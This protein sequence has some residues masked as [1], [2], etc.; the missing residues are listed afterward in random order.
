M[1][2]IVEASE[3]A[4]IELSSSSST[5]ISLPYI[6][7]KDG[8]PLH[9]NCTLTKAK[10]EQLTDG[11][12]KRLIECGKESVKRSGLSY[13]DLNGILLVGG[14]CRCPNVQKA[15]SD[16]FGVELIKSAN[17]DE[18]VSIGAA[19]QA[20]IIVGGE[21]SSDMV[22]LDVTPLSIG[23]ETMGGVMT[24]LIESNTTI[25]CRK[26][27]I[28]TTAV[29]NQPAVDIR[30]LQGERPMAADN[31]IIGNFQLTDIMPAKRGVPKIEVTFDIDANGILNVS[32][33]DT[34][35]GKEQS[36]RIESKS[37]LSDSEIERIKK[38]AKEHEESDKKLKENAD[39]LNNG[40]A[41]V[42]QTE[43]YM[44]QFSD[45][46]DAESKDKLNK[47]LNELKESLNK[48]EYNEVK[49]K[50]EEL[51]KLW[52]E[53]SQK[54]YSGGQADNFA[55]MF[56]NGFNPSYKSEQN[57]NDVKDAEFEEVK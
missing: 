51:N 13:N 17:L 52:N 30:V 6:S 47:C 12:V 22:L 16:E 35:T 23:I 9:L 14:S 39:I 45:K 53:I 41:S 54:V 26:S 56:T 42:F 40:D 7:V 10:F 32:A 18:A 28:F 2:R 37:G 43:K 21:G 38:E 46:I 48:K 36:I 25:P 44:E 34:G 11:I 24:K 5:E 29:D 57:N 55:D 15:L 19:I 49:L 1:Q 33:K 27:E 8:K 20:N 50:T 4:K 31:K 3:K